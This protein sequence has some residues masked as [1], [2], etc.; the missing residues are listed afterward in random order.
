MYYKVKNINLYYEKYGSSKKCILILP[1]WGETRQSFH[2]IIKELQDNF[3]IYIMDYPGFGNSPSLKEEWYIKD[4][5]DMIKSF[6]YD[7]HIYNPIIIAHS[8]GG[9]ITAYLVGKYQLKV[10]KIILIDVAGIKR[11]KKIVLLIKEKIYKVLKKATYLLP[12]I[13]QEEIRQKLLFY[14]GSEDY[15]SIPQCMQK[16]FQNIIKEDL[17]KYYKKITPETLIIWGQK[18][19][20]TPLKDGRYL[21]RKIKNAALIIYKNAGHFSYLNNLYLTIEIIRRFIL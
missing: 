1:G 18:D 8:F 11:R 4:Y 3:S 12:K 21:N 6:L 19:I 9:R 2:S 16:T 7:N 20:E 10:D 14:F 17:R 15:T 13:K 5:A